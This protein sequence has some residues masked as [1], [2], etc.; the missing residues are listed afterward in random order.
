MKN[1]M[2]YMLVFI[3]ILSFASC[4]NG[5]EETSENEEKVTTQ[6]TADESEKSFEAEYLA[7]DYSVMPEGKEQYINAIMQ[8]AHRIFTSVDGEFRYGYKGQVPINKE[9]CYVFTV[10]VEKDVGNTKVG[11]VA[12]SEKKNI[13]VQNDVTGEYTLFK[14]QEKK[15]V[16]ESSSEN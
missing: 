12:V 16:S 10:Y 11:C 3:M 9:I 14:P 5:N 13:Y 15:A 4:E 2:T 6:K 1:I 8:N 7:E